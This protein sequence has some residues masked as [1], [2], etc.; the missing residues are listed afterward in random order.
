MATS[1]KAMSDMLRKRRSELNQIPDDAAPY[2]L[3]SDT[4]TELPPPDAE[5]ETEPDPIEDPLTESAET[6]YTV[7]A[8][9]EPSTGETF[10]YEP[11]PDTPGAWAVYPPGVPCDDSEYRI[12]MA[13]PATADDFAGMQEA[14]D[15]VDT[16][17]SAPKEGATAII[18]LGDEGD[19]YG[20][21]GR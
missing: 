12:S 19:D 5:I 16:R 3:P 1:N 7:A 11:L 17:R 2:E 14:I 13:E 9:G 18:K 4:E 8:P 6:D 20:G 21:A 10:E 15:A